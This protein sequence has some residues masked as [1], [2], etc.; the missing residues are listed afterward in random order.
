VRN[1]DPLT[2]RFITEDPAEQLLNPYVFSNNN[3]VMFADPD[4]EFFG[5]IAGLVSWAASNTVVSAAVN[6]ALLSGGI[7]AGVQLATTGQVNFGQVGQSMLMGG[8]SAGLSFGIGEALGHGT[9]SL[10]QF[11]AKT[12]AHGVSGG[13]QSSLFGGSFGTGFLAG[14]IGHGFGE[15][16]SAY[17]DAGGTLAAGLSA[18]TV[19]S[20]TGGDFGQGFQTGAFQ[21]IFNR[22]AGEMVVQG[23]KFIKDLF[24]NMDNYG[25][26]GETTYGAATTSYGTDGGSV[27]VELNGGFGAGGYLHVV[28][29]GASFEAASVTTFGLH[30]HLGVRYIRTSDGR[31][32]VGAAIGLGV[33]IGDLINPFVPS[34]A[35]VHSL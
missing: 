7:S 14:S 4:G 35:F 28:Q 15:L 16:G 32:G 27:G 18:G 11:A 21:Y 12:I 3:P 19:A 10:S 8:V 31:H 24:F 2:G 17:G 26:G 6:G 23:G 33:D 20:L 29:G 22:T 34:Q 25:V 13:I 9:T 5:L 1:Y 30:R